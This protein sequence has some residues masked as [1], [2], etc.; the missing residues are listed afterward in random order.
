MDDLSVSFQFRT[1][2]SDGLLLST[3]LSGDYGVLILQLFS[4]KLLLMIQKEMV[5][6]QPIS[7]GNV[8]PAALFIYSRISRFLCLQVDLMHVIRYSSIIDYHLNAPVTWRS[9]FL[10][11]PVSSPVG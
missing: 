4:G 10:W 6:V 9:L 5:N 1:W 11:F 3:R 8:L 2:N 7:T